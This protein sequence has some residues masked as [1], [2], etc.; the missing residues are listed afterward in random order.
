MK[1]RTK[2]MRIKIQTRLT[3]YLMVLVILTTGA[4]GMIS[5]IAQYRALNDNVANSLTTLALL[6]AKEINGNELTLIR[7]ADSEQS[8]NYFDIQTILRRIIESANQIS[9]QEVSK[10]MNSNEIELKKA[11][12]SL[13]IVYVYTMYVEG[14]QIYYGV[15]AYP[16]TDK[17]NHSIAGTLLGEGSKDED[18]RK[19][20]KQIFEVLNGKGPLVS[21]PYKDE[22]GTWRTGIA[23]VYDDSG[24]IVGAVGVDASLEFIHKEGRRL[25]AS[26]VGNTVFLLIGAAL[27]SVLLSKKITRPILMLSEGVKKIGDGNFEFHA[28]LH[29]ND[30]IQDLADAFVAMN[31]N[32]KSY[33]KNLS[34]TTA[35][36]ERI[37]SELKI[38]NSIQSSMLPRI[39]PPFPGRKEINLFAVMEPAKEVGGDFYD[40]FFINED[41]LCICIADVSG[42][43]VPAALFM[44]ITKTLIKNQALLGISVEEILTTVNNMLCSD[45]DESMF[46]TVFIAILDVKT[47]RMTFSNAGHNLP[48]ICSAEGGYNWLSCK[49]S[50]VLGGMENIKYSENECKLEKGDRLFIYTDGITEA[51]N[52]KGQLY[53]D[54]R[55][56]CFLNDSKN[57]GEEELI[58]AIRNDI[59]SH[60]QEAAQSDD[61]TMVVMRYNGI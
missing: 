35:A 24:K 51:M 21:D 50:F 43:G 2:Q 42:K 20:S 30:E 32:L 36:K 7:S 33:I 55:L 6:A 19:T 28:D 59:K 17:K 16:S 3:L 37:E 58:Q 11:K 15:D 25:I 56:R 18:I 39:F 40:F 12:E 38:A 54:E 26:L 47:G 61:I 53:S 52:T 49:K 14:D 10:L 45:N 9:I 57:L 31:E 5:T 4:S 8:S 22:F 41:K 23:A 44:V 29:T 1:M 13:K 34:K 46:V 60:V 48:L 27:L